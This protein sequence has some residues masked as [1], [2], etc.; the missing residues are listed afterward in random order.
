MRNRLTLAVF[1]L[2]CAGCAP[3]QNTFQPH[4]IKAQFDQIQAM[5]MLQ[6]GTNQIKG[7]AFMRQNGGGVVTCAGQMV[8]LIPATEY[9]KERIFILYGSIDSGM[10]NT[11]RPVF[12]PDPPGYQYHVRTTKCDAQGNFQFNKVADGEFFIYTAVNWSVGYSSQ[13]GN[14][15]HRVAVKNS[16]IASVIL[17]S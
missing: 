8:Y 13:G 16:E 15:M 10:N 2:I 9:A 1:V 12:E 7:N 17:S 11:R 3:M 6:D 5:Q 14:L 4:Q